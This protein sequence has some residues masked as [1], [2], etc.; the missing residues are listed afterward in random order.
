MCSV[1]VLPMR[2]SLAGGGHRSCS[3]C[4]VLRIRRRRQ[5]LGLLFASWV[6]L[7]G[8]SVNFLAPQGLRVSG[9]K[10]R[11]YRQPNVNKR[12]KAFPMGNKAKGQRGVGRVRDVPES[13]MRDIGTKSARAKRLDPDPKED[14][15]PGF[16]EKNRRKA[17]RAPPQQH[18]AESKEDERGRKGRKREADPRRSSVFQ[19]P[20]R[21]K[22]DTI[23]NWEV[24]DPNS[25]RRKGVSEWRVFK[26]WGDLYQKFG[27]S[28]PAS[29]RR[30]PD[31][32]FS[33]RMNSRE[34]GEADAPGKDFV[35]TEAARKS[36]ARPNYDRTFFID[37][38]KGGVK[39]TNGYASFETPTQ[40]QEE[41]SEDSADYMELEK[42]AAIEQELKEKKRRM[43]QEQAVKNLIDAE[44]KR[45]GPKKSANS[46]ADGTSTKTN[47]SPKDEG[48]AHTGLYET[49]GIFRNATKLQVTRAYRK[50]AVREHPDKAPKE[51]KA[52]AHIIF[53]RIK[54]AFDVLSDLQKRSVYDREGEEGLKKL[55]GRDD[56]KPSANDQ[57]YSEA[58]S[59]DQMI[60]FEDPFAEFAQVLSGR[61]A[62]IFSPFGKDPD[63]FG[64]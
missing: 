35:D 9:S 22:K 39:F 53:K 4:R 18:K 37:G 63:L 51:K 42:R 20:L 16:G 58:P 61:G 54:Y 59:N 62:E 24:G 44:R 45:Q 50:I 60:N 8:L 43:L 56:E 10:R 27:R 38:F 15:E 25:L 5:R 26:P 47:P 52:Q 17:H 64:S 49:L 7:A 28:D 14:S 3:S 21:R 48:R 40:S 32:P 29:R 55:E 57:M 30:R 19:D 46:R 36:S 41:S 13:G 31:N 23:A 2:I 12:P 34:K 11:K 1:L 6:I 33:T